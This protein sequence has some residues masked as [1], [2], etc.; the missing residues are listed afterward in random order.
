MNDNF[1]SQRR[2]MV[3]RQLRPRGIRDTRVLE[4]MQKVPRHLF[5]PDGERSQSYYDGPLPIG[6]GQTIS[7]PYIVAY[8]TE[9]LGLTGTE[10]VLEIG[11]GSGYQTA[12]LAEVAGHVYTI[13]VIADLSAQAKAILGE[14]MRYT[15]IDFQ[16]GNGRQGWPE[17]APFDRIIIT[18]AAREFPATLFEQLKVGGLSLAPIGSFYQQLV[19]YKR[20]ANGIETE[21]L[22]AVSF[23][24]CV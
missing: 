5:V 12:V 21:P 19:R 10:S 11:T 8:M 4:A 2:A 17:F 24:P 1:L 18:A 23:V 6:Q 22:I 13:E 7:Q 9:I 3:D 14:E 16:V 20:T 15:N